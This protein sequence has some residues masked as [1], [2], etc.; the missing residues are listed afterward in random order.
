MKGGVG[1]TK[2]RARIIDGAECGDYAAQYISAR[3]EIKCSL[4]DKVTKSPLVPLFQ[5]GIFGVRLLT[6]SGKPF[7]RYYFHRAASGRDT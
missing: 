7:Y 2:V 5:R 3:Y 1:V 4:A 6:A